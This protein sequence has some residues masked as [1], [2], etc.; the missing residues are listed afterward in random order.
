MI[1]TPTP[2]GGAFLIDIEPQQDDRGFFARTFDAEELASR[3]LEARVAQTSISY[4]RKRGTLRGMH[5]QAAPHEETKLV[6]C[7]RGGILDVIADVRDSSPTRG[8]WLAVE[9]S[10]ENHRM[11]YIPRGVAHGFQTLTD[12]TEVFYQMSESY[13]PESARGFRWNDPAFAITWPIGEPTMSE[14]D[15]GRE[16]WTG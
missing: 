11:L 13:H 6:R 3:G 1:F 15:R 5:Y 8:Q 10:A 4:N 9:L 12:H 7:T 2:I 16:A 14:S